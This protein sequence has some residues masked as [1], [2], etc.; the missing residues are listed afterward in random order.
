MEFFNRLLDD[1]EKRFLEQEK[2]VEKYKKPIISFML[3]IPGIEKSN[4]KIKR[5]HKKGINLIKEK[6]GDKILEETYEEKDTGIYYLASVDM[7]G[8][9]LKNEMIEIEER[10]IGRLFDIDVFDENFNQITRSSLNMRPRKCLICD[11]IARICIKTQKHSY[12]ELVKKTNEIIDS[13]I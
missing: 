3:N 11:D 9:V 8:E 6:I 4:E 7:N 5:F 13:Y 10:D 1:R 2:L 12:E